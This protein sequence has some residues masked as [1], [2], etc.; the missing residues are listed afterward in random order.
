MRL[1]RHQIMRWT[2]FV[3]IIFLLTG[4]A[5]GQRDMAAKGGENVAHGKYTNRYYYYTE[6]QLQEKNGD[7]TAAV[8]FLQKAIQA[9]PESPYLARELARLYI[10]TQEAHK[11]LAILEKLEQ[12]DPN[13]VETLKMY[14]SVNLILKNRSAAKSIYER[15][16]RLDPGQE[17]IYLILG[18]LYLQDKKYVKARK[19][20]TQ[21]VDGFPGSYAGYFFLG[22]IERQT[23][24][25]RGAEKALKKAIELEP[26]ILE[27]KFEL[28]RLY[29][30]IKGKRSVSRARSKKIVHLYQ[31]ILARFPD[32]VKASIGLGRFYYENRQKKKAENIFRKLGQQSENDF[33][34][35]VDIVE[36]GRTL[37]EN[38]LVVTEDI[39]EISARLIVNRVS[40]KTK[41]ARI[42]PLIEKIK[43]IRLWIRE[44]I[45][46]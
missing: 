3:T 7:L 26:D 15:V 40:L 9:D 36:S 32:N 43:E 6:S 17:K 41:S 21:L 25:F 31:E 18:G 20:F 35:I 12:D 38:G 34:V 8:D 37:K 24:N 5:P 23:G 13:D 28:I 46:K 19:I 14:G 1:M 29:E 11:S 4:C 45:K 2:L 42:T 16:L 22:R 30:S 33:D 39:A 27:S 10:K 44:Q